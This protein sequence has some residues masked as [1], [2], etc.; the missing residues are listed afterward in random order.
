MTDFL[1]SQMFL[2]VLVFF[3]FSLILLNGAP[4]LL[5]AI[6]CKSCYPCWLCSTYYLVFFCKWWSLLSAIFVYNVIFIALYDVVYTFYISFKPW[7]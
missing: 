3:G 2:F 1:A 6:F 4:F 7:F 5:G